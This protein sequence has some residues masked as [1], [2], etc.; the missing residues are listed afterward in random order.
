M[1][2]VLA[3]CQS[4][5]TP[6]I[7]LA[8]PWISFLRI[9]LKLR[10]RNLVNLCNESDSLGARRGHHRASAHALLRTHAPVARGPK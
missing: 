2:K 10:R 3:R 9:W 6:R 8:S 5:G 1:N 4:P 7:L